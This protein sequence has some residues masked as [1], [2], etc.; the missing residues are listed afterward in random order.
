ML[1][2]IA[3]RSLLLLA[4]GLA[5]CAAVDAGFDAPR[6]P[7]AVF[8]GVEPREVRLGAVR[9][10]DFLAFVDDRLLAVSSTSTTALVSLPDDFLMTM[11]TFALSGDG[12][13]LAWSEAS[14]AISVLTREGGVKPV[15][16]GDPALGVFVTGRLP[17]DPLAVSS[18]GTLL[19][20]C[21]EE[22]VRVVSL[23][24]V[25]EV[26]SFATHGC[27]Y[28]LRFAGSELAVWASDERTFERLPLQGFS[29]ESKAPLATKAIEE[30]IT[31]GDRRSLAAM[32]EVESTGW[33]T[34]ATALDG[35]Q[36]TGGRDGAVHV[37]DATTGSEIARFPAL[38]PHFAVVCLSEDETILLAGGRDGL[39]VF[40]PATGDLLNVVLL[41]TAEVTAVEH[42]GD[43]IVA[44]QGASA[45]V[46]YDRRTRA[47]LRVE[48]CEPAP[49]DHEAPR[50]RSRD[51]DLEVHSID[52]LV[53]GVFDTRTRELLWTADS[54]GGFA[55]PFAFSPDGALLAVV[56]MG[57]PRIYDGRR[58]IFFGALA[59]V[60]RNA[61]ALDFSPDGRELAVGYSDGS[62][63]VFDL[64]RP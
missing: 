28:R 16:A 48:T 38:G 8:E 25:A 2:G 37:L 14:R 18:D 24:D 32:E 39:G 6:K 27:C 49:R 23:P 11:H 9:S 26:A 21:R 42:R 19:A 3:S 43:V 33:C 17:P 62:L 41:P 59:E 12:R 50:A 40:S 47:R 29:V 20:Y 44:T 56:R 31:K 58:G 1:A 35:R 55:G 53:F 10:S 5:G 30:A 22:R 54:G 52:P 61:T 63:R 36:F 64:T 7:V 34:K 51:G 45:R 4:L 57:V 13:V 15:E 46:T 60:G